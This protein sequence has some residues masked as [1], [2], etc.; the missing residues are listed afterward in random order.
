MS[1]NEGEREGQEMDADISVL[2]VTL[3]PSA[4]LI[5]I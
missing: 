1:R 2:G 3:G 5:G 4:I